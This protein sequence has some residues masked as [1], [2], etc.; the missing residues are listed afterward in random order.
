MHFS[1]LFV[2]LHILHTYMSLSSL[3]KVL[4]LG[5][6]AYQ[7]DYISDM[8]T[9]HLRLKGGDEWKCSPF[10]GKVILSK[11]MALTKGGNDFLQLPSPT[12]ARTP[13]ISK[14]GEI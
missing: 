13:T 6:K 5:P 1:T 4:F 11:S 7:K 3:P 2:P 9:I 8:F 10:G 14:E 12:N